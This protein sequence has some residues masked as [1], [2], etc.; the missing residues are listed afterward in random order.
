MRQLMM[1]RVRRT[2]LCSPVALIVACQVAPGPVP[3]ASPPLAG[4]TQLVVVTTA[5]WDS[6]TGELRRFVRSDTRSSWRPDGA[7][8]PIVVGRTGLAWGIGFDQLAASGSATAGPL[9]M[10][11]DGRSP[12]GVFPLDTAFGF[13]P[14]DSI[15]SVRL[16]YVQLTPMTECIDDT[17]SV[18][19]NTVVNRDAV[20]RVDWQSSEHMRK[21]AQY[22]FGVIVGYN[23]SP[24]VKARG[25]CI[26]LHIWAGPRSTTVGCTALDPSELERLIAWLDPRAR[27]VVVQVPTAVYPLV[28]E[29]WRLPTFDLRSIT[30]KRTPGRPF[31]TVAIVGVTVVDPTSTRAPATDQTIVITDGLIRAVGTSAAIA[32]PSGA[33]RLEAHGKFAIPGLWDAHVHFMNTGVTALPLLVANGITSVREMGGYIDSTRA[34][35]ARMKVGTL[36]GPRIVTPGPILESPRYLQGVVERSARGN[37]NLALRVLPYRIGVAD[38]IQARKAIDSLVKLHVDFVKIRTSANPE[39][40]YAILRYARQAGLRVAAH[41]PSAVSLR[42]AID[43]GQTDLEHAILPPLSRLSETARDS[44]YRTFVANGAWY[45]PTL[46]V[47]GTVMLTGDSA[48]RAIFSDDAIR[49]DERRA[50]A[51]QWLLG[52]WRMQVDERIA[53]TT[54]IPVAEKEEAYRSSTS[55]VHRMHELGVKILAGTDAGSV[56][57]YPGF[58]L[59]EELQRLVE[60]AKLSPRDALWSATIGPARFARLDDRLGTL[61]PGMIADI[62]LLDADPLA[63]IRNTRRIFAVVQAGRVFPRAEL[64][65]LLK[66]VRSAASRK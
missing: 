10:E 33:Q 16:P 8:V 27:P 49:L 14:A 35:Q 6:T 4:A 22:R 57:V 45:T 23:A 66:E 29:T 36:V 54:T 30:P 2:L 43:S 47:S 15:R 51:S 55:D 63:N 50:Y 40:L 19:Y 44:I 41:Q 56:L 28:R 24:P 9:K 11:G 59:H 17:A 64:D 60:D 53:D 34:W 5:G 62:V 65:S 21:V 20:P 39:A 12:A 7:A 61:S 46:T 58:G 13:S 42:S 38:S 32:I 25:S 52:W 37:P 1:I 26:F 3:S 31:G 18:H 48:A